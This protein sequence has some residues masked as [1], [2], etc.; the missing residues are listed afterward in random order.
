M[1]CSRCRPAKL[2]LPNAV[3]L[4][5]AVPDLDGV[6]TLDAPRRLPGLSPT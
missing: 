2:P 6:A 5:L 1:P 4:D 3:I